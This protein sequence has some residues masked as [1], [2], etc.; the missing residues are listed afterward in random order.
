[1]IFYSFVRLNISKIQPNT[2]VTIKEWKDKWLY[3]NNPI[4]TL[5]LTLTHSISFYLFH[6]HNKIFD[7]SSEKNNN[8]SAY[9]R[10]FS[11]FFFGFSSSFF[12]VIII[13]TTYIL[14]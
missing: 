3:T 11:S 8:F 6:W 9:F 10:E 1:M 2:L 5:R 7:L 13:K 14:L 12:F 4:Q